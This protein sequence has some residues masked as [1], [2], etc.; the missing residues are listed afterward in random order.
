MA[1]FDDITPHRRA[2]RLARAARTIVWIQAA[3][4]LLLVAVARYFLPNS[5]LRLLDVTMLLDLIA[6][7]GVLVAPPLVT[8]LTLVSRQPPRSKTFQL[9]ATWLLLAVEMFA[10]LPMVS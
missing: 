1:A 9:V 4:A 6:V 8:L 3:I 5:I 10:L 7:L 2:D